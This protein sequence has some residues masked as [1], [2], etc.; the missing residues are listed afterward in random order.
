MAT[1][2]EINL[3]HESAVVDAALRAHNKKLG[4]GFSV[5]SRPDPPD[6]ILFDGNQRTWMEHTDAFYSEW[7]EDITSYAA[8]DKAHKP[9]TNGVHMDMDNQLADAFVKAVL[10]KFENKLYQPMLEQFGPGILVVGLESPWLDE[11]SLQAI[12]EKWEELGSIDLSP[13][14]RWVYLGFRSCGENKAVLW[15][16]TLLNR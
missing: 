3:Q 7:A 13:V 4:T 15:E 8:S 10:K 11:E 9:M 2:R 16:P 6:A 5:E 12:N 14:F 1:R